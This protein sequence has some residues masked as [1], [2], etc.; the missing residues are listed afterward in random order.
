MLLKKV[1]WRVIEDILFQSRVQ[2]QLLTIADTE[3][4]DTSVDIL[5][6]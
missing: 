4:K 1:K 5:D 3:H 6:S 2:K